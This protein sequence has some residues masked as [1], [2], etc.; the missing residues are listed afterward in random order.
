MFSKKSLAM[1]LALIVIL[2][3]ACQ[4]ADEPQSLDE[5]YEM[6]TVTIN[7]ST[8]INYSP[9]YFAQTEGYFAE[10]GIEL[11]VLTF[12]RVTEAVPLLVSG[13]LDV[14]AGSISAGLINIFGQEPNVKAVADRGKIIQ[15]EC[16][17]Q[18]LLVRKDLYD[19]GAV[20][21][22][23]D[24]AGLTIASTISATRGFQLSEFLAKA[25]LTFD[26][27]VISD[28]PLS[29]SIDAFDNKTLDAIVVPE[30]Y[31]TRL[32]MNGNTVILSK[33]EDVIGPYQSSILAFGP[34]LINED[35]ELGARFMAAYLKGVQKYNEGK[36]EEN[37]QAIAQKT[38]EDIELVNAAC[39][40]PMRE[41][42]WIDFSYVD[43]FQQW[44]FEMDQLDATITEE[45]FWDP[46]FL[47]AGLGLLNNE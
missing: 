28:L 36:T 21:G 3:S 37:I 46:S 1:C 27:V 33:A 30:T 10:Y 5:V 34:R 2:L 6:T 22:P 14:Y 42:G 20:T 8:Q 38:G 32:L 47:E 44:S 7:D 16:T 12:N 45:Q 31:L 17:F 25:N 9:I 23:E 43:P 11:E 18:A 35:P 13:D 15:G 24:L 41:D 39:W 40:P 26:D 4:A 29:S 19:S